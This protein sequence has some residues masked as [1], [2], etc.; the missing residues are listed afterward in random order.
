M[1]IK[2]L[3]DKIY[4]KWG[5]FLDE[6]PFDPTEFGIP[7]SA[8]KCIEPMQLLALEAVR[9]ALSRRGMRGWEF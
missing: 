3:P 6:L 8:A 9:R 1:K 2:R 4:S 7:P 5:G